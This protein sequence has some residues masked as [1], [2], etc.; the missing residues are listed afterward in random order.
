MNKQEQK[1]K[2][3]M[4]IFAVFIFVAFGLIIIN[5]KTASFL[6]PKIEDKM[7]NYIKENYKEIENDIDK[8]K[9]TYKTPKYTM[10]ITNKKNKYHTFYIYYQ[11]K[12]ITDT[13]KKDYVEGKKLLN[14]STS[15]IQKEVNKIT[16]S[17]DYTITINKKLNS[18]TNEIQRR[19]IR[20]D[21]L[22]NLR[23]YNIEKVYKV[24]KIDNETISKIIKDEI[25]SIENNNITP[26]TYKFTFTEKKDITNSL[27]ISNVTYKFINNDSYN[28]IIND[29]INDNNSKLVK[30]AGIEY[31][32][33]N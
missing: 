4:F 21:N 9:V 23:I 19:I 33:L 29:I 2:L 6:I 22:V 32:Y 12:K 28:E 17:K 11:D 30:N 20:E 26:R 27:E 8:S 7:N 1:L 18:F 13:Y 15:I 5:E 10:K 16:K 25:T 24:D 31:K 14:H 3:Q